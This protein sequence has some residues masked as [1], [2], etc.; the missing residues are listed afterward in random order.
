MN[1]PFSLIAILAA[2][3]T[4]CGGN[5]PVTPEEPGEEQEKPVTVSTPAFAKGADI[6]WVSEMEAG[7][8]KF[9]KR[10]GTTADIMEV[11]KD[12]GINSVRLRVWV[13]PY[14]GWSGRADVVKLASRASQ[15]GLAVMVDF[16]YSDF[17]ADPGRQ[18]VPAAWEAD[19]NDPAK[20]ASRVKEHT[21]DVLSA[22]REAG[23]TP[24]WVQVGNETRNGM[25]WPAGQLWTASGDIPNGRANFAT[26]LSA[27]YDA[28]KA[29][30]PSCLV[31]A[32][33][34][35]AY[36]DNAWW[37]T[38]IKAAGGQF[39]AIALSHYPQAES[40]FTPQE[41]N[42]KAIAQIKALAAKFSVPVLISEVGVKTLANETLAAQVLTEFMT[43][44]KKIEACKG[45]F[46]WEPEVFGGWKPAIYGNA[47]LIEKY[48]GQKETWGAYDMGAFLSDGRPSS[49]LDAF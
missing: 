3:C 30:F 45:V 29:I 21:T 41:Y 18:T 13:N 40:Q 28:V 46:Y 49:V 4:G 25:L 11:L 27:G 6:S 17:F 24:A 31:L 9:R 1:R 2:L 16:H 15:A 7:G 10:D 19:K 35:N 8:Q 36:E 38:Q 34:N 33:L 37:F 44:A 12:V 26:L 39:D 47:D 23:V 22:L 43:E 32:H 5:N 20:M 48:T 42:A 14:Q